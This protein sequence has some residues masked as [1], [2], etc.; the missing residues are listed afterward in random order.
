MMA[1]WL[2]LLIVE[3]SEDD[4]LL[5]LHHLRKGGYDITHQ[6]VETAADMAMA[7]KAQPW[8]LVIADYFM[9]KFT[10]L[11]A[12]QLLQELGIDIPFIVVSGV[13][14]EDAAVTI[15]K[16]GAHDYLLK[17]NLTR[18]VPA[19]ERELREA[20]VRRDKRQAEAALV[21][22]YTGLE[23]L[24]KQRTAELQT[25]N[26]S[27]HQLA[28]IV[29]SSDDAIISTDLIGTVISWNLGAEKIYGCPVA[30]AL[31]QPIQQLIKSIDA[32]AIPQALAQVS[33]GCH[34]ANHQQTLHQRHDGKWI[35]VFVTVSPV[36]N[37]IGEITGA[38]LI[39][40]DISTLE[41][42]KDEFVSVVSHELRTPLTSIR[43]SLGLLLTGKLGELPEAGQQFVEIAVNNSDRLVRLINDILDLQ[44]LESGKITLT[45]VSC[46][47]AD[48]MSHA[49]EVMAGMAEQANVSLYNFPLPVAVWVDPDRLLQT[50]TNL[51]SNAIKFS[52]PGSPVWLTAHLESAT[53]PASLRLNSTHPQDLRKSAQTNP[54]ELEELGGEGGS[55]NPVKIPAKS[56]VRVAIH[57]HGRGIPAEK[58]ESIFGRFQQV[59]ASDARQQGGTGLGLAICRSIVLQHGGRIWAESNL[60][61]GSTFFLTL[62]LTPETAHD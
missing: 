46:D 20:E 6:Q 25:A 11:A 42:M 33:T 14:G 17:D 55:P 39:V 9:P 49:V 29:A 53:Q 16:A 8:D 26:E 32:N 38:S 19:I 36:K 45:Q 22:A 56:Y 21:E 2:R 10:A 57:D 47:L 30:T 48:L 61:E 62:P 27:L 43:A 40:R 23:A 1:I 13:M 18:L 15:M 4:V 41:K 7:L 50:L 35:D 28:A 37:S 24:V 12:L 34:H 31:G 54:P 3:D 58:L 60:G 51:L 44:R 59:D 52:T 5:L